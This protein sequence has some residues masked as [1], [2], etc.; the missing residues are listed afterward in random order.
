MEIQPATFIRF[1]RHQLFDIDSTGASKTTGR[2]RRLAISVECGRQRRPTLFDLAISLL[3]WQLAQQHRQ[4]PWRSKHLYRLRT[5]FS[6]SQA[7][8]HQIGKIP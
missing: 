1:M 3:Q 2:F 8:L 4:T 6:R 5:E 7:L